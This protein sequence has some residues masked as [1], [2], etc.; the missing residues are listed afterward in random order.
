MVMFFPLSFHELNRMSGNNMP[1]SKKLA[2]LCSFEVLVMGCHLGI[3]WHMCEIMKNRFFRFRVP[4][5]MNLPH[6]C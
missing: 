2:E 5:C 6:T 3:Y 4:V 1:K